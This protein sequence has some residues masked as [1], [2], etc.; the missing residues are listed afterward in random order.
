MRQPID[1]RS[2]TVTRPTPAM[3]QAMAGAEV[4]D[5]V[6]GDDPTVIALEASTA[7]LLGKEAALFVP[8]GTMGNEIALRVHARPGQEVIVEE[9][10]H[11]LNAEGGGPAALSGVQL[12]PLPSDG[13]RIE[14]DRLMA[15]LVLD[16]DPHHAVTG[17][18]CFENT[19]NRL[20]GRVVDPGA[21]GELAARAHEHGI[22]VHLDGA[23]LWNAAAALGQAPAALAAAVDSVMVCFSKG[24]GAPVGSALAGS[25]E[26]I[27]RARRVRKQ[28]GGGLRQAG[29]L[30]EACRHA[31]E[32]HLPRL[33]DDHHRARRL[34]DLVEA[35]AGTRILGG[36]PETNIVIWQLPAGCDEVAI[37]RE[38]AGEG[39]LL[40]DFGPGLLRAVTHLDI[41]D[42]QVD[43]AA[44]RIA[45]AMA[46]QAAPRAVTVR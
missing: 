6:F 8:S 22:P 40:T 41:D 43:F 42:E 12:R 4:G 11:I 16:D 20:G 30:A 10:C 46:R 39:I 24:L 44:P 7:A 5:D 18:V 37:R 34:A 31:I 45:R 9:H 33:A 28:F 15:A 26:F 3:R 14:L 1:L 38:L 21:I 19:H 27:H 25:R 17:L 29:I 23:R 36:R 2:D 32:H 35:P 13:G